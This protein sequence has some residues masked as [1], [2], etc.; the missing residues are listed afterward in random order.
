MIFSIPLAFRRPFGPPRW[1]ACLLALWLLGPVLGLAQELSL[2][3]LVVDNRQNVVMARFGLR[4]EGAEALGRRV[5]DGETLGLI[6]QASLSKAR[7]YWFNRLLARREFVSVLSYDALARQ[8]VLEL[9]GRGQPA[10]DADLAA[11]LGRSWSDLAL[12]LGPSKALDRGERYLL[13]LYVG[14]ERVDAPDWLKRT[15]FFWSWSAA[16]PARYQLDF[17]Y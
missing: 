2:G 12:D 15:L 6:C 16:P 11:L 10:R 13:D 1:A 7:D 8:F 17:T 5:M 4:V 9:P 3:N 14:L